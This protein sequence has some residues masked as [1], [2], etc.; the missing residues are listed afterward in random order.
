MATARCTW[1][2][3]SGVDGY[4]V[5]LKS[6]GYYWSSTTSSSRARCLIFDSSNT[7]MDGLRRA[8]GHSVRCVRSIEEE[9]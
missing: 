6:N 5:Y 9:T 7:T 8:I 4:N 3:V 1:T 2:A